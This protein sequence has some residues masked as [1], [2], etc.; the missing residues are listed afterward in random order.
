MSPEEGAGAGVSLGQGEDLR[1]VLARDQD[2]VPRPAV[3]G[4]DRDARAG[5]AGGDEPA[6]RPGTHQGLVGQRHH[7]GAALAGQGL[8][9]GKPR[10]QR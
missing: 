2:W 7:G 5:N 9:G 4:G 6:D 3:V 8:Q 10:G 1:P